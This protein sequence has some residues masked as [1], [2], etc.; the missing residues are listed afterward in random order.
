MVTALAVGLIAGF[1]RYSIN[2]GF[3]TYVERAELS[4]VDSLAPVLEWEYGRRKGWSRI[5]HDPDAMWWLIAFNEGRNGRRSPLRDRS[6]LT[7]GGHHYSESGGPLN[8][9]H[10]F[11][12]GLANR[13]DDAP[14]DGEPPDPGPNLHRSAPPEGLPE[15]KDFPRDKT[16][17]V[18]P[19]PDVA[20]GGHEN[21]ENASVIAQSVTDTL[22]APHGD[23][24]R[25]SGERIPPPFPPLR[26][27]IFRRLGLFDSNG[28]LVWGNA[29]A[30]S[31]REQ[32][33]LKRAGR[34]IGFLKLAPAER[35]TAA[36]D[37]DFVEDQNRNL[38]GVCILAFSLAALAGLAMSQD[39]VSAITILVHGTRQLAAGNFKTRIT[40]LRSDELGQLAQDFNTLADALEQHDRGHRQWIADTSHELRTPIAVLRAQVEALQDGVQEVNQRTLGVL[41]NEIMTLNKLVD[42]LY[43]LAK[44]DVG[45][46]RYR[47]VPVDVVGMLLDV[48]EG[49][50]ERFESKGISV[51]TDLLDCPRVVDA[52]GSRVRQLFLNLFENSLR[53][54]DANGKFRVSGH[55]EDH[56]L[57]LWFDDSHPGVPDDLLP[58]IFERF[59]RGELS[60]SR[61]FGGCG[62]GLAICRTIVEGHGGVMRAFHSPLGGLRVEVRLP[63]SGGN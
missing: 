4:R 9:V 37:R 39:L 6:P 33:R 11:E 34:V 43:H 21:H 30:H 49:F 61:D 5:K 46:L 28:K 27:E 7:P 19:S 52:D 8:V 13:P 50:E 62:L 42:D 59:F 3:S 1:T 2:A 16:P 29:E 47:F 51:E 32:V 40:L 45:E 56:S 14:L 17:P 35:L 12:P 60:R 25:P 55:Q 41:H 10:Q 36:M 54:T 44:S 38:L 53:Y 58:K 57:I 48:V 26:M 31:A 24:R 20:Q 22:N 15:A 23:G 18:M 63:L